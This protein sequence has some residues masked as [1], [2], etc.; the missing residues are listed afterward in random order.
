MALGWK[1]MLRDVESLRIKR[2]R[3]VYLRKHCGDIED[4]G[5]DKV[6]EDDDDD[7]EIDEMAGPNRSSKRSHESDS[8]ETDLVPKDLVQKDLIWVVI[9]VCSF[10]FVSHLECVIL[11]VEI[12]YVLIHPRS[13]VNIGIQPF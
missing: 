7:V 11:T 2:E 8:N 4:V 5:A 3:D 6:T 10:K 1:A 13:E 12:F 9:V